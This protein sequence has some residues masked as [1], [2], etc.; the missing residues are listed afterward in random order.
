MHRIFR[1]YN[2][3]TYDDFIDQEYAPEELDIDTN[4]F[5]AFMPVKK[6]DVIK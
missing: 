4:P 5:E 1:K 3:K 6:Y 2:L